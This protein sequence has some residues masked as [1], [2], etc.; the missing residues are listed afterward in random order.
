MKLNKLTKS[1]LVAG[2]VLSVGAAPLLSAS[3]A[4]ASTVISATPN[5]TVITFTK[6]EIAGLVGK[7]FTVANVQSIYAS[8][9]SAATWQ[10]AGYSKADAALVAA[11]FANSNYQAIG[12]LT[13]IANGTSV[14]LK[15]V[16]INNAYYKG[17]NI[18]TSNSA[19]APE[20]TEPEV[21]EPEVTEPEVT[22]PEVT[23]PEVTEPTTPEV[24]KAAV[25]DIEIDIEYKK[26]DIELDY[27]VKS[28]GT[29]KAK[30]KNEFTGEKLE[31][32]AAQTKIEGVLNGLDV[33][34]SSNSTISKH[35]LTK[36]KAGSDFKK[37]EFEVKYA[38]NTKVEFK[39]K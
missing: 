8:L 13:E 6:A 21:T 2:M 33:K 22:E 14:D 11:R 37:F 35:V 27:E 39:I 38:N 1:A 23:E 29:V 16:V 30:Y 28:N 5:E 10:K 19:T 15:V 4:Q 25:K 18:G 3:T 36:L 31:G 7:N 34:N 32:K 9:K 12:I 24:S 20:V 26:K 17:V